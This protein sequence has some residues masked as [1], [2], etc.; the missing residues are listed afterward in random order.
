MSEC[1]KYCAGLLLKREER[2][3]GLLSLDK[4]FLDMRSHDSHTVISCFCLKSPWAV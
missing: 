2:E 3:K 4:L 1:E